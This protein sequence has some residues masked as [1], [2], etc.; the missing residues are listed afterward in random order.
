MEK[1][2][3]IS[4]VLAMIML[5]MTGCSGGKT[6]TTF[7]TEADGSGSELEESIHQSITRYSNAGIFSGVVFI[8]QDEEVLM[9]RAYGKADYEENKDHDKDQIYQIG[10]LTKAMTGLVIMQLQQEEKLHVED[11]LEIYIPSFPHSNKIT[12]QQLLSH[13]SGLPSQP[14]EIDLDINLY[15]TKNAS[16]NN[17]EQHLELLSPPGSKFSYSN[18]GYTLLGFIIEELTEKSLEDV[19]SERIFK[20]LDMK[21]TTFNVEDI[22]QNQLAKAYYKKN[23]VIS[24]KGWWDVNVGP[25]GG[26]GL[27]STISDLYKWDQGL[28]SEKLLEKQYLD[29][30]FKLQIDSTHQSDYSY[31]WFLD[32]H[33]NN[34]IFQHDGISAGYH[35]YIYRNLQDKK[36]IIIL[37]NFQQS[38]IWSIVG[39]I[40]GFL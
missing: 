29:E 14:W 20:P 24:E 23:E 32:T 19:M 31:G 11:L 4:L 10:S 39:D 26:G 40:K 15:R 21:N 2:K 38:P 18:I 22:D 8:A 1:Y 33:N 5:V 16:K 17:E 36:T 27:Y 34:V 25:R 28:Y 13:T 12:I 37:S 9:H 30:I 3:L 6:A 35:T 7:K